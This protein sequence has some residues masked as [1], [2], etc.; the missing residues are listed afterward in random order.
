MMI[1]QPQQM[2]L[3]VGGDVG[4]SLTGTFRIGGE[5]AALRELPKG[6]DVRVVVTD[7]DGEVIA[8]SLGHR[9][10]DHVQRASQGRRPLDRTRPPRKVES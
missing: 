3:D 10:R 2:T 5:L 6:A 1:E 8:T 7:E 9:Q 4:I